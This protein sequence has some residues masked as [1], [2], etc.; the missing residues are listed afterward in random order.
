MMKKYKIFSVIATLQLLSLAPLAMAQ[1]SLMAINDSDQQKL[2]SVND[3]IMQAMKALDE[4][5]A[6]LNEPAQNNSPSNIVEN[7]Q[8]N[9]ESVTIVTNRNDKAQTTDK[10]DPVEALIATATNESN[11]VPQKESVEINDIA[12]SQTMDKLVDNLDKS[13]DK[14][15]KALAKIEPETE[16]QISA[17]QVEQNTLQ[18]SENDLPKPEMQE[19]VQASAQDVKEPSKDAETSKEV[20]QASVQDVK[21]PSKDA[22]TSKEV[23]QASAQDVKELSKDEETS[24]EVVQASAQDVKEPSKE[25]E[26]SKEA[27]IASVQPVQESNPV[28]EVETIPSVSEAQKAEVGSVT[29]AAV[30]PEAGIGI[31]E[32]EKI[33]EQSKHEIQPEPEKTVTV[34]TTGTPE[35]TSEEIRKTEDKVKDKAEKTQIAS[36]QTKSSTKRHHVQ[37]PPLKTEKT[38]AVSAVSTN[39]TALGTK[40]SVDASKPSKASNKTTTQVAV[41]TNTQTQPAK[42]TIVQTTT[43]SQAGQSRPQLNPKRSN[44]ALSMDYV[45]ANYRVNDVDLNQASPYGSKPT[46]AQLYQYAFAQ[47]KVYQSTKPAVGDL[48]FFHNTVDRN[49]DQKWNDWHTLVGIVEGVN[50]DE[51][52]TISVLT[53]RTDRIERIHLNLK[54]PELHKSRKGAILNS[55][56]RAD[57]GNNKGTSAKLFAGFA[58]LL[59]EKNSFTLIDNW[60]PG[61]K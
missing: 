29:V 2:A 7:T 32:P 6:M 42:T 36:N 24:K 50:I 17:N 3:E 22:E 28:V 30:L 39:T 23:V 16:I 34:A 53:Y 1:D 13:M 37:T 52:Q 14:M 4:V 58:N 21:E 54:Y 9:K 20:V 47:K 11:P 44:H 57:Q 48:V 45:M 10:P 5:G 41:Q 25:A 15:E 43:K 31:S 8:Q 12:S 26:T 60:K 18:N 59:G 55:Q 46:I 35:V 51:N 49:G 61:M 40:A 38:E 27:V 56:I 19:T 33:E